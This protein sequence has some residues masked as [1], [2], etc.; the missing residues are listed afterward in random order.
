MNSASSMRR[1]WRTLLRPCQAV[2]LGLETLDLALIHEQAMETPLIKGINLER[3][4]ENLTKR[5]DVLE[6]TVGR[7]E[8]EL[9]EINKKSN[10]K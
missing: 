5:V 6:T 3:E 1:K 4:V 8:N 7:L 10:K 2:V 9:K